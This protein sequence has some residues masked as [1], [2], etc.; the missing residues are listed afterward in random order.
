MKDGLSLTLPVT[1]LGILFACLFKASE[2]VLPF[3]KHLKLYKTYIISPMQ[4]LLLPSVFSNLGW[5]VY[6]CG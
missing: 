2:A 5:R 4:N 3:C 1:F 6:M